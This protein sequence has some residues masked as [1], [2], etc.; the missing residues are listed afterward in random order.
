MNSFENQIKRHVVNGQDYWEKL[1]LDQKDALMIAYFAENWTDAGQALF[2]N[3]KDTVA[4]A[5]Y[6]ADDG[7][8]VGNICHTRFLN[9]TATVAKRLFEDARIERDEKA[10]LERK[11]THG[12][13]PD[14]DNV[15]DFPAP[16]RA[17]QP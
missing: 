5:E 7:A 14:E 6:S 15:I 17:V 3:Q 16:L 9:Y 2:E 1:H 10:A 4:F 11:E 12:R 8:H 13:D